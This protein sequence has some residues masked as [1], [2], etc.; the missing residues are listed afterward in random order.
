LS[1]PLAK[2]QFRLNTL[3]AY[4]SRLRC[5]IQEE[6]SVT[7]YGI[8][9]KCPSDKDI[10]NKQICTTRKEIK[11]LIREAVAKREESNKMLA[12]IYSLTG[13]TTAEKALKSIIDAE[14]MKKVWAKIRHANKKKEMG[15]ISSLQ[16]PIM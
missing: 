13:K 12:G 9:V 3:K 6:T 15:S 1:L 7:K 8:T 11:Q 2:A 4:F 16:V 5:R 14:Q 10:I